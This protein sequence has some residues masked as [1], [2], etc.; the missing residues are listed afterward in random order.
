MFILLN[1]FDT[2]VIVEMIQNK[3]IFTHPS[4]IDNSIAFPF[5][6]INISYCA[7]LNTTQE[8][9]EERCTLSSYLYLD[10]NFLREGSE[11]VHSHYSL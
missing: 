11:R 8:F 9:C 5:N 2:I 3:T 1:Y 4:E 6:K 10:D 7:G